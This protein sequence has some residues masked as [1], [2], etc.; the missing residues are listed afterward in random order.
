MFREGLRFLLSEHPRFDIIGEAVDGIDFLELLEIQQPDIVLMDIS[1][2][3]MDGVEATRRA[4]AK[5]PKMKVITLTMF[6]E[7][8]YYYKMIH[9]GANGFLLK[10][11]GSSELALGLDEVLA[12]KDYFSVDLLKN[13]VL[14]ISKQT[15]KATQEAEEMPKLTQREIEVLRLI[16]TG[17]SAK[18]IAM[19]LDVSPRTVEAHKANLFTKTG[20]QNSS[21]LIM[22]ALRLKL[23]DL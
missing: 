17:L 14:S 4:L 21:S 3:R 15:H 1:M 16:C 8:E 19:E 13:L 2:P 10:E 11:S 18:E 22:N 20:T 12:G 5:Y 23:V 9:A 6:G 7:E